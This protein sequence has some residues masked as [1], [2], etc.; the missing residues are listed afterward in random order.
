[1]KIRALFA[2]DFTL[3]YHIQGVSLATICNYAMHIFYIL[4]IRI[5]SLFILLKL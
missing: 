1:M 3:L 4:Y 2:V 5:C